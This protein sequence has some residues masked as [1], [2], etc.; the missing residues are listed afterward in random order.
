MKKTIHRAD[1]RGTAD[2]GW[3]KANFSFSFGNHYDPDRIQFGQLR[4]LNDDFIAAGAGFG[5]HP[6]D[7]MEIVTIP[8][9]GALAHQDSTGG[10]GMI[11]SGEVQI[12]SAGTG[13]YH[14]EMNGSQTEE[15]NTLQIW[16]LPEK[17][18]I[19]PRYDQNKFPLHERRNS[20]KT[21][22]SPDDT[23]EEALWINQK[24]YFNL[25]HVEQGKS[26]NYSLHGEGQGIYIF[27]IKGQLEV[28]GETL[29][30]RDAIGLDELENI[31]LKADAES[32][33]VLI[34]IPM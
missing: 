2:H 18:D 11:S 23:D 9:S 31:E 8:L 24:A 33:F 1:S 5:K 13:I 16:V 20:I 17:R 27:L 19:E 25:G 26:L 15:A 32:E 3:L 30:T 6:H 14:S 34:E 7:N 10:N 4:V 22:V 21:A 12:M 28:A 29:N